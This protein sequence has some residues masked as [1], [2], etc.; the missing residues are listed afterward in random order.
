M[1]DETKLA[2]FMP[3]DLWLALA[4]LVKRIDHGTCASFASPLGVI[5]NQSEGE[6]IW[7]AVTALQRQL[8]EA[9]FAPR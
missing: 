1:S 2:L 6:V 9:G 7:E 4:L 3:V 5:G 8:A